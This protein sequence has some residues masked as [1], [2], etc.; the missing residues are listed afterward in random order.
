MHCSP[1]GSSV[2][3]ISRLRILE[4]IATSSSR[5]LPHPWQIPFY[6]HQSF[7]VPPIFLPFSPKDIISLNNGI[8]PICLQRKYISTSNTHSSL[9]YFKFT[10]IIAY[11]PYLFLNSFLDSMFRSVIYFA[12][13]LYTVQ[14]MISAC[15]GISAYLGANK[16]WL[17]VFCT[18]VFMFSCTIC[19][20][21][22]YCVWDLNSLTRDQTQAFLC[23]KAKS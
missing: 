14:G 1:P 5:G 6:H 7:G 12:L 21:A 10:W 22:L 17:F 9:G 16:V 23:W 8:I 19:Y 18:E 3:R 4:R 20:S 15:L 13:I 2:H 11:C